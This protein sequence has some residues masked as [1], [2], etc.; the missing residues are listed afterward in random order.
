M[1]PL[2]VPSQAVDPPGGAVA[3]E[4]NVGRNDGANGL[5]VHGRASS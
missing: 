3:L 1:H 2:A 4:E 5:A